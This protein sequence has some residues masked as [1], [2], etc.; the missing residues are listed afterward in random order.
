MRCRWSRDRTFTRLQ[1]KKK[2]PSL[3]CQWPAGC[4]DPVGPGLPASELKLGTS[5][6]VALRSSG[7]RCIAKLQVGN[8]ASFKFSWMPA[9]SLSDRCRPLAATKHLDSESAV[10]RPSE[11]HLSKSTHALL[12]SSSRLLKRA[13]ERQSPRCS[14]EPTVEEPKYRRVQLEPSEQH[15]WR[16]ERC[17]TGFCKK[18][19][20]A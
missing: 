14:A 18:A 17:A 16:A 13:L 6:P 12:R 8:A 19:T 9:V 7:P 2:T 5:L 20:S 15:A 1:I 3:Q 11:C 4:E 10:G